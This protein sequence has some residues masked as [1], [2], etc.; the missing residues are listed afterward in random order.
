MGFEQQFSQNLLLKKTKLQKTLLITES[1]EFYNRLKKKQ[2]SVYFGK[3]HSSH[4][5]LPGQFFTGGVDFVGEIF[6]APGVPELL[7]LVLVYPVDVA[8]ERHAFA[9]RRQVEAH[10]FT[11]SLGNRVH[12]LRLVLVVQLLFACD[13][14]I[15][16]YYFLAKPN[17]IN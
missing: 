13:V 3:T 10:R 15:L 8:V 12:L 16:K 17:F 2:S 4:E 1:E 6:V 5:P 7:Q 11:V 14:I 9:G